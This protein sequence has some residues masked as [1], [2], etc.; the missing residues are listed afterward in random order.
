MAMLIRNGRIESDDWRLLE[1]AGGAVAHDERVIVPLA[2]WRARRDELLARG[3]PLG[4]LLEPSD[5]PGTIGRELA[6]FALVAVRFPHFTD[7]RGYSSARLLRERFGWA[8][9]LRAVGD[10]QLD[11]LFYLRRCGFDSFRLRDGEEAAPALAAL[12]DFSATYQ[13]AAD[14]PAPWFRRRAG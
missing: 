2:A 5:P 14:Q 1:D 11:Q 10:V 3:A 6:C 8:G 9:E 7:G 12:G 4:V 13:A